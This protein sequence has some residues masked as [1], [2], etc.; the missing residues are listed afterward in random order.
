MNKIRDGPG[1]HAVMKMTD[2]L[3]TFSLQYYEICQYV[4]TIFDDRDHLHGQQKWRNDFCKI[5]N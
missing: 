5:I 1:M 4:W 3:T 2:K